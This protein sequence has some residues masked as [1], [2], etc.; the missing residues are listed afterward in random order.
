MTSSSISIPTTFSSGRIKHSEVNAN[1]TE[2]STKFNAHVAADVTSSPYNADITGATDT[3]GAFAALETA[4]L[5]GGPTNLTVPNGHFKV[6]STITRHTGI[7]L[8][9]AYGGIMDGGLVE[10]GTLLQW[11]GAGVAAMLSYI[12]TQ[13]TETT[14]LHLDGRSIA[15]V[16]GILLD[17][18]SIQS[19]HHNYFEKL[20]IENVD[21]AFVIGTSGATGR[22]SD[23]MTLRKFKFYNC[24]T[25]CL[26]I[27]SQNA[28]QNSDI[29]PGLFAQ[30]AGTNGDMIRTPFFSG[31]ATFHNLSFAGSSTYTGAAFRHNIDSTSGGGPL[32]LVHCDF[33]IPS[34]GYAFYAPA[35]SNDLSGG[36]VT[37]ENCNFSGGFGGGG[38]RVIID[39]QRFVISIGNHF[40]E[41]S[42]Q[43][44]N[45][46][47]VL[48]S[49]GD[50]GLPWTSSGGAKMVVL[51]GT[52]NKLTRL[53]AGGTTLV[54]GDF[55]L[56]GGFG[57]TASVGTITGNDQRARFTVTSTGTG[58]A[59]NPTIT[60]TFK[61]GTW[62]TAPFAVVSRGGG[63][64]ATVPVSV[65]T[66]ATTA[67]ITF[68]GTPV[69]AETYTINLM[70]MG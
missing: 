64:Q 30:P 33:E 40:W 34:T 19:S 55:A 36:S 57:S 48:I 28:A 45:A 56:S 42:P 10:R 68:A 69:A 29:G 51:G 63:S 26:E 65:S 6:A 35:G 5:A 67:V 37:L 4:A 49:I 3:T 44:N 46:S 20:Y 60:L 39:G 1:F 38:G 18:V 66:T 43:I 24:T 11:Y 9:G 14:G 54:A 23:A 13:Y 2:I 27:N 50:T 59:A 61:D 47:S 32:K 7:S 41:T 31:L 52:T 62:T 8:A 22:Q 25:A 53:T 58:Q 15:S 12:D 21:K 70:V 17:S 16:I